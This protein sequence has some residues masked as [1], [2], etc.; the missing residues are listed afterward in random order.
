MKFQNVI[1]LLYRYKTLYYHFS[2]HISYTKTKL[3]KL[4]HPWIDIT[5]KSLIIWQKFIP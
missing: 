2:K 3:P 1:N 4:A 5:L